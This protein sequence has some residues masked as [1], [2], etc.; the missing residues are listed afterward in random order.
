MSQNWTMASVIIADADKAAAKVYFGTDW[1]A[2]VAAEGL[3]PVTEA[4]EE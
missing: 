3:M 4:P 2:A 1:Q